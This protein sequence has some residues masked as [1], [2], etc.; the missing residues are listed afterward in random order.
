MAQLQAHD[1][2]QRYAVHYSKRGASGV[3]VH[4]CA[5]YCLGFAENYKDAREAAAKWRTAGDVYRV[6][7]IDRQRR[8][9]IQLPLNA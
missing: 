2:G 7:I 5:E 1:S 9:M 3:E 6:W 8:S 4:W